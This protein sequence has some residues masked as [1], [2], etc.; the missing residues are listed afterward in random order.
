MSH[1]EPLSQWI[2]TVSTL[3]PK[4]TGLFGLPVLPHKLATQ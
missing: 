2:E 1:P 4:L 3:L